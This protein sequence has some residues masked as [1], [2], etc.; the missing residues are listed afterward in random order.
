MTICVLFTG[1]RIC[2]AAPGFVF[3]SGAGPGFLLMFGNRAPPTA[4]V[5]LFHAGR[6]VVGL[7]GT[8]FECHGLSVIPGN[9]GRLG[10]RAGDAGWRKS[11]AS[12]LP[13]PTPSPIPKPRHAPDCCWWRRRSI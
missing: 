12:R 8:Y 10:P 4:V 7:I 11:S 3:D 5:V 9:K 1:R 13:W 2:S 6:V